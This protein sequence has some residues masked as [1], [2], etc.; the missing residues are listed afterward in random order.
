MRSYSAPLRSD[1]VDLSQ[2]IAT[3]TNTQYT[4][5]RKY[6]KGSR[7][8]RVCNSHEGLIRKYHMMI[9]RQCFRERATAIGFQKLN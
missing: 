9:C 5:P 3:M 1:N 6:G 4:H 2:F 7:R 8:C